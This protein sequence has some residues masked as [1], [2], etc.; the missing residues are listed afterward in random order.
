MGDSTEL[1]FV[2]CPS[3]RSLVPAVSTRCRMCGA[4]LDVDNPTKEEEAPVRKSSGRVRQRTMSDGDDEMARAKDIA[5]EAISQDFNDFEEENESDNDF[6]DPLSAYIEEMDVD[7]VEEEAPSATPPADDEEEDE[8]VA[9][10]AVAEDIDESL[11]AADVDDDEE[12]GE[13]D[14]FVPFLD[15]DDDEEDANDSIVKEEEDE[16]SDEDD[17]YDDVE[18]D[19]EVEKEPVLLT[20]SVSEVASQEEDDDDVW[21]EEDEE[22]SFLE[23]KVEPEKEQIEEEVEEAEV[24]VKEEEKEEPVV[25][26]VKEEKKMENKE[27]RNK[28]QNNN[29][30][31]NKGVQVKAAPKNGR[32]FGWFVSYDTPG[33]RGIE[34]RE[35]KFFITRSSLKDTDF[36]LDN[37]S[38]STPHALVNITAEEGM[39]LQDLMSDRGV[40][41]R[42]RGD[43]TYQREE[44][45]VVLENGDWVR[46][47]DIEFLVTLIPHVGAR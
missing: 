17:D 41:V 6:N 28:P 44:E 40:F 30:K 39:R 10:Q 35:G 5:K 29:K 23:E 3:C 13:E 4:S 11:L 37:A 2:R 36:V 21:D 18:D 27:Q 47:G 42:R 33:G 24:P 22:D 38:I 16:A 34:L 45:I 43:D 7:D 1:T 9:S 15:Q 31:N 12:T 26:A 14:D 8:V 32:L 19:V 20:E 46:F 25:A